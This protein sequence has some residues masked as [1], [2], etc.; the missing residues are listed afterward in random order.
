MHDPDWLAQRF[1]AEQTRLTA[2]AYRINYT[3]AGATLGDLNYA[4][5][6]TARETAQ[7]G[8]YARTGIPPDT[9]RA[10]RR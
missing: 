3:L 6:P 10:A 5:D 7:W 4:Y 1:E 8:S 2:V 9:R